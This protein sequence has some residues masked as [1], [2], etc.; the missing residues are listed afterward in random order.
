MTV[1]LQLCDAPKAVGE[2]YS[3]CGERQADTDCR[4]VFRSACDGQA[5]A[6]PLYDMFDDSEAK[7]RAAQ[8]AGAAP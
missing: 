2:G 6:V 8:V 4:S 3:G 1:V 7:P 5:P